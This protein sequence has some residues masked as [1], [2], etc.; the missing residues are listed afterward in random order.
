MVNPAITAT[1]KAPKCANPNQTPVASTRPVCSM[2]RRA[3][4]A[5]ALS[6][7]FCSVA[8]KTAAVDKS[9]FKPAHI[10]PTRK[11]NTNQIREASA[12]ETCVEAQKELPSKTAPSPDSLAAKN[13]AARRK[14]SA[15]KA[16]IIPCPDPHATPTPTTHVPTVPD[17]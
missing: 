7:P 9:Q 3:Q 5:I 4:E 14:F 2:Q 1:M 16:R 10:I 6:D 8:T 13:T 11:S 12:S 15:T 17:R